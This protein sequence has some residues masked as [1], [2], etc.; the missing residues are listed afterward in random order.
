MKA[1]SKLNSWQMQAHVFLS[2]YAQGHKK[3]NSIILI[4]PV[5]CLWSGFSMDVE[6]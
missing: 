6:I 3:M 1:E 2:W 5:S 4:H